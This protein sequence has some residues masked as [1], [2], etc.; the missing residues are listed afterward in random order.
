[1]TDGAVHY[2]D[3]VMQRGIFRCIF[4][5]DSGTTTPPGPQY[6]SISITEHGSLSTANKTTSQQQYVTHI[7]RDRFSQRHG[8]II[9]ESR[10]ISHVCEGDLEP[11]PQ[12]RAGLPRLWGKDVAGQGCP[13]NPHAHALLDFGRAV[14]F[15]FCSRR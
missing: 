12:E 11:S 7:T 14:P 8:I 3:S 10:N 15:S 9:M 2:D 13:F 1:M 6:R 5:F 4:T